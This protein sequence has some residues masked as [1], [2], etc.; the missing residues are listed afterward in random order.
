MPWRKPENCP[1]CNEPMEPGRVRATDGAGIFYLPDSE[2]DPHLWIKRSIEKR[3][4]IILDG[5]YMI[6]TS[7]TVSCYACRKCRQLLISY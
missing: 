3:N 4:G 7:C 6:R 2:D 1:Y 5:P